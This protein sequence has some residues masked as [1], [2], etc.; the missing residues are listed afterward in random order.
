[1]S[2][3][4]DRPS[5]H[6]MF[7]VAIVCPEQINDEILQF[8]HWMRDRFGCTVALRSPAH[9]TL[10]PPFWSDET[11]QADLLNSLTSFDRTPY[12]LTIKLNGFS[13]F[14][15]RVLFVDV[16]KQKQLEDLKFN[17]GKHFLNCM[18]LFVKDSDRPFHPHVTIAN[19]DLKPGDFIIAWKDFATKKYTA[20]FDFIK[21]SLLKLT[22]GK[23]NVVA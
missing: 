22:G 18:N 16:E 15:N 5:V 10:I 23:W 4:I 19:R 7:F 2:N 1:M 11:Q 8:K 6:S 17:I 20:Q 14:G 3:S 12:K 9:I 13:H 21:P